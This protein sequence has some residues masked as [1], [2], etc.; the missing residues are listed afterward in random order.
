MRLSKEYC[1]YSIYK[2]TDVTTLMLDLLLNY[3]RVLIHW[4]FNQETDIYDNFSALT[5]GFFF[6]KIHPEIHCRFF[7]GFPQVI[8]IEI[9]SAIPSKIGAFFSRVVILRGFKAKLC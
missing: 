3:F 6:P 8:L 5:P 4:C 1:E 9:P 2:D 7:P